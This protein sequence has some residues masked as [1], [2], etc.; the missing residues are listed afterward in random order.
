MRKPGGGRLCVVA[1]IAALGPGCDSSPSGSTRTSDPANPPVAAP[2][3]APVAPEPAV[4]PPP[5]APGA[6]LAVSCSAAPRSGTAPLRVDFSAAAS[7]GADDVAYEWSF[8]DGA[9]S[10]NRSPSH[11]YE[12]PG[13]FS[14]SVRVTSGAE[15]A[16]CA[17]EIHVIASAPVPVPAPTSTPIPAPTPPASPTPAPTPTPGPTPTPTPIPSPSPTPGPTRVLTIVVSI[18]SNFP[19]WATTTPNG[20][21]CSFPPFA[22]RCSAAFPQGSVVTVGA[23]VS[24][25]GGG[26][27]IS[28]ACTAGGPGH[29]QCD[30]TMNGN[31]E[32]EVIFF[33]SSAAP[34]Q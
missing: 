18:Y 1:M 21:V 17:R 27:G 5:L 31:Q 16:T 22:N 12:T 33:R 28:G 7:A 25:F 2:S 3:A 20:I 14:A 4:T 34:L 8:G 13:T 26:A 23:S 10:G 32:V 11:V 9:T 29:A 19:G 15:T 6:P 30:V 24:G